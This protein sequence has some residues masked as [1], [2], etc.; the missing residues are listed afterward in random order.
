ML[1]S[2]RTRSLLIVGTVLSSIW[3]T[4]VYF[5]DQRAHEQ[6][7]AEVSAQ[8]ADLEDKHEEDDCR[9]RWREA[10]EKRLPVPSGIL[11]LALAFGPLPVAWL[12]GYFGMI[13][14]RRRWQR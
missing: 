8:C 12:A 11:S 1:G 10:V 4:G 14:T 5:L 2:V 13:V 3:A 9:G 7:V 6:A